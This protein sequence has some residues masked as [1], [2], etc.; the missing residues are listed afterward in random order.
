M[1]PNISQ[2]SAFFHLD[3][4]NVFDINDGNTLD[5]QYMVARVYLH[6]ELGIRIQRCWSLYAHFMTLKTA[7]CR[8]EN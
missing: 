1:Q 7:T 2:H 3:A 4:M 5:L 6:K 8:P